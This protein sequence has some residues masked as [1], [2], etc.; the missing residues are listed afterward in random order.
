MNKG[1]DR[2]SVYAAAKLLGVNASEVYRLRVRDVLMRAGRS[3]HHVTRASVEAYRQNGDHRVAATGDAGPACE[4]AT[5]T[6]GTPAA[7]GPIPLWIPVAEVAR[8]LGVTPEIVYKLCN[9]RKLGRTRAGATYKISPAD[10][11]EFLRRNT[12]R[13]LPDRIR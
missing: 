13:S 7:S 11:D 6:N 2:M 9:Q 1:E 8:R 4:P 3:A 5:G 12:F 10:L